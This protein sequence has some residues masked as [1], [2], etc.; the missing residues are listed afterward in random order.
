MARDG[1]QGPRTRALVGQRVLGADA[2]REGRIQV[3]EEAV[4]VVVVEED[5]NVG[6][7]LRDLPR[8]QAGRRWPDRLVHEPARLAILTALS[9]CQKAD[10]LLLLTITG[11][12][13]G[14]LS[15]HLTKLEEAGLAQPY[16]QALEHAAAVSDRPG[17]AR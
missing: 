13:K 12:T 16:A 8:L 4:G 10:F 3:E 17:L 6:A 1:R 2:Q 9:A 7:L 15:S 5:E 14:N 11:L